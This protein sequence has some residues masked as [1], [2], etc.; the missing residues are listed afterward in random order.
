[1]YISFKLTRP[2]YRDNKLFKSILG[3]NKPQFLPHKTIWFVVDYTLAIFVWHL[4]RWRDIFTRLLNNHRAAGSHSGIVSILPTQITVYAWAQVDKR[5][6]G[7]RE[8]AL[9]QCQNPLCGGSGTVSMQFQRSN[10]TR[11]VDQNKFRA[12]QASLWCKLCKKRFPCE[13]RLATVDFPDLLPN[14]KAWA[15][16]AGV[17]DWLSTEASLYVYDY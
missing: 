16:L 1:V 9:I 17:K 14:R 12:D 10:G 2:C 15:S 4:S 11:E 8:P 7:V 13:R 6:Y 3:F 5:P